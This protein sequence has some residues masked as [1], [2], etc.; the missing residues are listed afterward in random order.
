MPSLNYKKLYEEL[1]E[2]NKENILI[3]SMNDM[4][5]RYNKLSEEN[6]I[7]ERNY[8]CI[9]KHNEKLENESDE[10][11]NKKV[12]IIMKNKYM[13]FNTVYDILE[14]IQYNDE[15]FEHCRNCGNCGDY[16]FINNSIF[17]MIMSMLTE[18]MKRNYQLMFHNDT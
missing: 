12:E 8:E 13:K 2:S 18:I 15:E 9:K 3:L 4:K 14:H 16:K 17:D 1:I 6:E 10:N 7:L 11:I 5:D